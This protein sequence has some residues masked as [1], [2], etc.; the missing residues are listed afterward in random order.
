MA[1]IASVAVDAATFAID[2]LYDYAVPAALE[3]GAKPGVRVK[4][5]FSRGNRQ[6][7]GFV[8]SVR[9]GEAKGLKE[10]VSVEDGEPLVQEGFLEL[11][12]WM[13]SRFFCTL[14]EAVRAMLPSGVWRLSGDRTT[15][16][17]RLAVAPEEALTQ[18]EKKAKKAPSQAELLRLLAQLGEASSKE[19]TYFTGASRQSLK[20]LERQG[21]VELV[22]IPAYRRP[23]YSEGA[24]RAMDEL[25]EDQRRAYE[26]IAALMDGK[27]RAALLRGVTGSGKTAV[28][29]RLIA[30]AIEQG[31]RAIALVPE[32]ALTPQ[33]VATFRLHFGD[34]VAVLHSSLT[35]AERLDEWRRIRDG[36]VNVVV[37]T[38]SAVF[39]PVSELR[40]LIIDEEQELTYK[41]EM[42]P[43]YH[44]RDVAK[45]L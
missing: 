4:V 5:P 34:A 16:L 26:G 36:L 39:A 6:A 29:I 1:L 43:R 35:Q 18:A 9:E 2:K 15:E 31:G 19:L 17:A 24:S 32:I 7:E 33:L 42:T 37:G 14:Y 11:A 10:I 23:A 12:K 22:K 20:G 30:R 27:A 41:S 44:A 28:Y 8:F 21:L 40:L 45:F 25:T 13:K 38:R 3:A